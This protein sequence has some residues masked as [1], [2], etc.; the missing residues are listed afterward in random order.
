MKYREFNTLTDLD[1]ADAAG[2]S[3]VLLAER[4]RKFHKI[5][6]YQIDDFYIEVTH[7]THFNV[8]LHVHS[9]KDLRFLDPYLPAINISSVLN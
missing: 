1:R 2:S 3:G 7:H 8:V 5:M 9:F 6:L 4:S